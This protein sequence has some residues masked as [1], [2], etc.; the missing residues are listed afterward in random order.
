MA[1]LADLKSQLNYWN[2]QLTVLN[3]DLKKKKKRKTDIEA[4]IGTLKNVSGSNANDINARAKSSITQLDSAINYSAKDSRINYIF[5]GKGD[6]G[7]YDSNVS[8]ANSE[9]QNELNDTS[10]KI[11]QIEKDLNSAKVRISDLKAAIMVEEQRNVRD[12][13]SDF[14]D[15][16]FGKGKNGG[17]R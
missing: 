17:F 6:G 7:T 5:A 10:K 12:K 8:S 14:F 11:T 1:G 15:G 16:L 3:S 2:N 4:I 9:L 13:I